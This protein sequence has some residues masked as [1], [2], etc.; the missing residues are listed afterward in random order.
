MTASWW[1]LFSIL[2]LAFLPA[3]LFAQGTGEEECM[4]CM[5]YNS[6]ESVYHGNYTDCDENPCAYK[7]DKCEW[8]TAF[9]WGAF[10]VETRDLAGTLILLEEVSAE[11]FALWNCSG[12]LLI[13]ADRDEGGAFQFLD[14]THFRLN[15]SITEANRPEV[16]LFP[17]DLQP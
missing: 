5:D 8:H 13:V 10:R 6:C 15:L 9:N 11:R 3:G 14:P 16:T 17:I 12:D 1:R 7:G 4:R 2:L